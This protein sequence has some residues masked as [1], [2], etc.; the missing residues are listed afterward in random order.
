MKQFYARGLLTVVLLLSVHLLSY[1]GLQQKG[2]SINVKN[3]SLVEVL[4]K[5][6]ESA[7]C[8]IFYVSAD[9]AGK[10]GITI[11]NSNIT[12]DEVLKLA[13]KGTGLTYSYENNK[14]IISKAVAQIK[15]EKS[16]Q[17]GKNVEMRGRVLDAETT[18]PLVGAMV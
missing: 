10:G 17:K 12:V 13:L 14:I 8:E 1:A 5:I 2:I 15:T 9:V 4:N 6:K 16:Q 11:S 7:K 18:K 3:A